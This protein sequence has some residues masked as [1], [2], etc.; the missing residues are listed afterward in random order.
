MGVVVCDMVND[1]D[2]DDNDDV[3]KILIAG[4]QTPPVKTEGKKKWGITI[5]FVQ[6][7][8]NKLTKQN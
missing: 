6:D 4:N 7:E 2:D 8:H 1:D 5:S 3:S